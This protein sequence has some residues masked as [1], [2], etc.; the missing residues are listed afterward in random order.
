MIGITFILAALVLLMCLGFH[1]SQAGEVPDIF[2]IVNINHYDKNGKMDYNSYVTLKNT[3]KKSYPN[4]Y[5][6]VKLFVN[7][8]PAN[9]NLPTLNGNAFCSSDHTGI[10]NIGGSGVKGNMKY[11]TSR[12]YEG[13]ELFIDFNDGTFHPND[14]IRIEVY[15]TITG[16]IIS[17]DTYPSPGK[18][19]VQWFYN[20]LSPQAA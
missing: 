8:I 1:I 2:K 16:K 12:W 10:K 3:G 19:S 18:Y 4:G 15:D 5:L 14:I 9:A 7:G 6:S 20:F 11:A 17:R 13:Q